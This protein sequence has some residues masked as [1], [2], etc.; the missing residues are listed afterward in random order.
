MAVLGFVI[1]FS[2]AACLI[3]IVWL[4][5]NCLFEFG[6]EPAAKR[7]MNWKKLTFERQYVEIYVHPATEEQIELS[8]KL[9][10][11]RCPDLKKAFKSEASHR[12]NIRNCDKQFGGVPIRVPADEPLPDNFLRY[13]PKELWWY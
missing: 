13:A 8:R 12:A 10:I 1:F 5:S 7:F 2:F 9:E 6:I 4:L 11:Q 3:G